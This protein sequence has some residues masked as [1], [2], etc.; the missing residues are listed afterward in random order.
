MMRTIRPKSL[1]LPCDKAVVDSHQF[2]LEIIFMYLA[3][4]ME[5][6]LLIFANGNG[7]GHLMM[8]IFLM[9]RSIDNVGYDF[10]LLIEQNTAHIY[11]KSSD[12]FLI[13]I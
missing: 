1:C 8:Q 11:H 7:N 13:S 4:T 9:L 2:A 5:I 6:R 10:S 12:T 3:D